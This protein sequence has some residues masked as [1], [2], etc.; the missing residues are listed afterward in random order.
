MTILSATLRVVASAN[1]TTDAGHIRVHASAED[2]AVNPTTQAELDAKTGTTANI[3]P[4]T[5]P[6]SLGVEYSYNV[7]S[8]VQEILNRAGW[9]FNNNLALMIS[10]ITFDSTKRCQIALTE[11]ATYAE[12]QLDISY[13][14][15][16]PRIFLT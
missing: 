6:S 10:T 7:T 13:N 15:F 3:Y 8:I 1:G 14:R 4:A 12:P 9:V 16:T 5:L 2:S 11:H